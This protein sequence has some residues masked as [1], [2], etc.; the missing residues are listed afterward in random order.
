[1]AARAIGYLAVIVGS[2][3]P[4]RLAAGPK[5]ITLDYAPYADLFSRAAV[6]VH[7]GG[8]GTTGLAMRS[9]RPMLVMPRAWDQP[10]NAARVARLGI[11]RVLPW[12]R[13]TTSRVADELRQLLDDGYRQRALAVRERLR[14]EDGVCAACKALE[15]SLG[16]SHTPDA[17]NSGAAAPTVR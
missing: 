5:T 3:V 10:D 6:I 17:P 8:I 4:E 12:H 7:H 14:D 15:W 2:G 13:Y 9:G 1:T 16:Q 11:A